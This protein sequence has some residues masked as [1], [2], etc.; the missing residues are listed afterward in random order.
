[1]NQYMIDIDLPGVI[2]EDFAALI[3]DQ[4]ATVNALMTEGKIASYS[5]AMDRSRLWVIVNAATADEARGVIASFPIIAY[6]K[7]RIHE[8]MF[9]NSVRM[10]SPQ[11]SLN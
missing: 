10:L 11:F 4:R 9:S 7:F 2:T 1:M 3:P 8:L 5:L 6:I